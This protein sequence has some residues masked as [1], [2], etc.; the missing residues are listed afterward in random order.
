MCETATCR[1][2]LWLPVDGGRD[3]ICASFNAYG[4][5][6]GV[7]LAVAVAF[8]PVHSSHFDLVL[9][10]RDCV[11]R[12]PRTYVRIFNRHPGKGRC[13]YRDRHHVAIQCTDVWPTSELWIA[14]K[15]ANLFRFTLSHN[16][17]RPS[18][19]SIHRYD[20]GQSGS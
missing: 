20:A 18:H 16:A 6:R 9:G 10:F 8:R 11:G 14:T 19:W 15:S 13:E 7:N 5:E 12:W 17:R 2:N 4:R 3:R 1:S